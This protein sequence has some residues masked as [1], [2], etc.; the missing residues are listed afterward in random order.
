[1]TATVTKTKALSA[2]ANR[3]ASTSGV[4]SMPVMCEMP[5]IVAPTPVERK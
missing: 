2:K 5:T 1:M 3:S 4:A